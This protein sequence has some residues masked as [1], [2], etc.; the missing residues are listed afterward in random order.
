MSSFVF[1]V[2]R[3][4]KPSAKPDPK[5][6]GF[7]NYFTDHMLVMEYSEGAGWTDGR[8]VPYAPL[9]VDPAAAVFHYAQE[10]FEGLKAFKTKDGDIRLFRPYENA[11]RSNVSSRRLCI[12]AIDEELYVE[13]VKAL[14]REDSDWVPAEPGTSL[15]IRPFI[16]AT[17]AFLGV[18][19]SKDYLFCV[20][21]SPVGSYYKEGLTP[22]RIYVEDECVRSS[23]GGTGFAKTGANYAVGLLS[24]EKAKANG[25]AQVLWLDGVERRYV[26]EIGTSNAFFLMDNIVYT[27]P[28]SDT[29]LPGI[30]RKS[31]IELMRAWGLRVE[32]T[33]FTIEDVLDAHSKGRLTEA[34]A[35]GTAAVI[36]PVGEIVYKKESIIINNRKTGLLSLRLY[37]TLTG[38]QYGDAPDTYDWMTPI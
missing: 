35:T 16:I 4:D 21:L 20:I 17:E 23:G 5:E 10:V 13:A 30:T 33:R 6:L 37:E 19:P 7:G 22:T 9:A 18:R 34:F 26:E 31:A 15:Y 14:V 12:P 27:P 29:I 1:P 28:A 2:T 36:S 24:Q 8:I 25:C 3:N 38:I 32:E 11:G